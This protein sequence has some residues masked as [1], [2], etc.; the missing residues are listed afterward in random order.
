MRLRPAVLKME[1]K[2]SP[3]GP[4]GLQ[5]RVASRIAVVHA[6]SFVGSE[7]KLWV[8]TDARF[9]PDLAVLKDDSDR[10]IDASSFKREGSW[11]SSL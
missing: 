11:S 5:F 6:V 4:N 1:Y 7:L 10:E 9:A 2:L 8:K 3:P